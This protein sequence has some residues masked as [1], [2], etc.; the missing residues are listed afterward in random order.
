[1]KVSFVKRRERR[2][3]PVQSV[4][5]HSRRYLSDWFVVLELMKQVCTE[6]IEVRDQKLQLVLSDFALKLCR[7]LY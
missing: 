2:A 6:R 5:E 7:A 1:M 4:M 3:L